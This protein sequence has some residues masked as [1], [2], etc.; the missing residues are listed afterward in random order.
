VAA[1]MAKFWREF[2]F[3]FASM[4]LCSCAELLLIYTWPFDKACFLDIEEV[5]FFNEGAG[6]VDTDEAE[7][8]FVDREE[9]DLLDKEE[10]T[11]DH[12]YS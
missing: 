8:S 3:A 10:K 1:D 11:K 5:G 6:F 2:S 7:F 4:V 9:A 12:R